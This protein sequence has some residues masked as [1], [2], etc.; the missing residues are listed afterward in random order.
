MSE[1]VFL[2]SADVDIQTAFEFC[3]ECQVGRGEVFL[4]HLNLCFGRLRAFPEIAPV[5]HGSYRRLLV[6]GFP[7]GIFYTIEGQRIVVSCVMDLRQNPKII[8]RRL[9]D[10]GS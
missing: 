1:L 7:F 9:G 6:N 4:R 2:F 5:F 10:P 8:R 3:E